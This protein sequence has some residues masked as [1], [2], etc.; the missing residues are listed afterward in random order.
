L[1][2]PRRSRLISFFRTGF[3]AYTTMV[4]LIGIGAYAGVLPTALASVPNS[5]KIMHF[6]LIGGVAF[7]LDGTLAHRARWHGRGSLAGAAVLVV[8][9][10]AIMAPR[11]ASPSSMARS[12]CRASLPPMP[13]EQTKCIPLRPAIGGL[14]CTPMRPPSPLVGK[15][16]LLSVAEAKSV[17]PAARFASRTCSQNSTASELLAMSFQLPPSMPSPLP[18]WPIGAPTLATAPA[19]SPGSLRNLSW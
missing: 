5:D 8:A 12:S 14:P 10:T 19:S 2:A 16:A 9:A 6:I 11:V 18:A 4:V 15:L 1:V 7:F 3:V 13:V 17:A